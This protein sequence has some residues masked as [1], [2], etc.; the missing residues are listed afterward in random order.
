MVA[1]A[2]TGDDASNSLAATLDALPRSTSAE[3]STIAGSGGDRG[4]SALAH[5]RP[6]YA[7]RAGPDPRRSTG[8]SIEGSLRA[9]IRCRCRDTTEHRATSQLI[10]CTWMRSYRPEELFDR[11]GPA[12]CPRSPTLAPSGQRRMSANPHANGGR[13]T[14]ATCGCRTSDYAVDGRQRRARSHGEATRV[15]GSFLRDVMSLNDESPQLP[16]LR[17]GRDD[18]PIAGGRCSRSTDR[19][20]VGRRSTPTTITGALTAESWRS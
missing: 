7:R 3:I 16:D 1:G 20:W 4:S 19:T 5:D 8:S 6:P 2:T 17:P 12:R 14:D 11:T 9:A 13:A 10:E 15:I 18:A